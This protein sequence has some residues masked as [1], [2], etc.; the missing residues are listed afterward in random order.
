LVFRLKNNAWPLKVMIFWTKNMK[1]DGNVSRICSKFND[2][3]NVEGKKKKIHNKQKKGKRAR[4]KEIIH[5]ERERERGRKRERETDLRKSRCE[6][7]LSLLL[8]LSIKESEDRNVSLNLGG[9]EGERFFIC[10]GMVV[11]LLGWL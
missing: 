6:W 1:T 7:Q 9:R 3:P 2:N 4:R 5:R 11:A 8:V 10:G